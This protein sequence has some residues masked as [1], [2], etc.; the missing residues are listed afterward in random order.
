MEELLT[1]EAPPPA[2]GA[3]PFNSCL[4]NLFEDGRRYLGWHS[5]SE[6]CFGDN[7]EVRHAS[8]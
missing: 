3:Q 6:R 5:D 1:R 7:P 2:G 4:M 8:Q